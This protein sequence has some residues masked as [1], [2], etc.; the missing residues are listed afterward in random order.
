MCVSQH[1]LGMGGVCPSACWDTPP[2]RGQNSRHTL[3]KTLPFRN[4]VADGKNN[5]CTEKS[6]NHKIHHRQDNWTTDKTVLSLTKEM[7]FL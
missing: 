1:A 2:P 6:Q 7:F 4:Y 5:T 3:V